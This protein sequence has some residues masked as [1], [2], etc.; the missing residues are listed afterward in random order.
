VPST[1]KEVA[2]ILLMLAV[3]IA[4]FALFG[5]LVRFAESAIRPR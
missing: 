2:V 3:L 5:A 1:Q 4:F